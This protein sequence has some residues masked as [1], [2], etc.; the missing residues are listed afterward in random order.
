ML[1][2]AGTIWLTHVQTSSEKPMVDMTLTS[3]G[4]TVLAAST[5]RSV[6]LFDVRS[7]GAA[8]SVA[9]GALSHPATPSCVRVSPT[10]ENQVATG[11]FDGVVRVWDVRSPKAAVASFK[12]QEAKKVLALDWHS[13]LIAVGGEGGLDV[14]KFADNAVV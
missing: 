11:A 3:S 13:G 6:T 12:A 1:G 14:W 2:R 8:T 5:D 7:A 9:V 10:H 4:N